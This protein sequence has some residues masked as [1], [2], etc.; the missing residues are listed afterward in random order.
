MNIFKKGKPANVDFKF[1]LGD[2]VKDQ[3]T[4]FVGVVLGRHQWLNGCN[5]YSVQPQTLK[6]GV[7]QE[8]QSF[9]E[10]QLDLLGEE[11]VTSSRERGGPERY[12]PTPNR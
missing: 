2:R 4:G 5:T 1:N 12:V 8:R 3:V 7:P 9:D 6:D 11:V 10:P